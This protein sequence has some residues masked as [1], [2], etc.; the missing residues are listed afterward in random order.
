MNHFVKIS[1]LMLL[2][3]YAG[4]SWGQNVNLV[5]NG[6]FES[7][8]DPLTAPGDFVVE[9][10][11]G[12]DV[13]VFATGLAPGHPCDALDN[14]HGTAHPLDGGVIVGFYAYGGPRGWMATRLA[15]SLV[16][17]HQYRVS[18]G[19]YL[20]QESGGWVLPSWNIGLAM[21]DHAAPD[22]RERAVIVGN[23]G[24]SHEH[25]SWLMA[26]WTFTADS[27]WEVLVIGGLKPD[28][29]VTLFPTNSNG[30]VAYVWVDQLQLVD[31]TVGVE[32]AASESRALQVSPNPS[33]DGLCRLSQDGPWQVLDFRGVQVI[34]GDGVEVD[35]SALPAGMYMV[36]QGG[37]FVRWVRL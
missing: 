31:L 28:S 19:T 22:L 37:V 20:A 3:A 17:G 25:D 18:V 24:L 29:L 10:W 32:G 34:Q 23:D 36:V 21:G 12:H 35:G 1:L 13:E 7:L 15:E 26:N 30:A 16:P 27:A 4:L 11:A 5:P 14:T 33:S 9:G 6:S 8:T 2:M